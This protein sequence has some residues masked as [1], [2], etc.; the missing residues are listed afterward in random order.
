MIYILSKI[1][2]NHSKMT[3]IKK[4]VIFNLD[5]KKYAYV[6]DTINLY[7]DIWRVLNI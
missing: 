2:Y 4:Y 1:F 3:Y 7:K 6:Y 5:Y